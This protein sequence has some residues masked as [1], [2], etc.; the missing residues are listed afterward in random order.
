MSDDV[1][2]YTSS[3]SE[4][5]NTH[6]NG[7]PSAFGKRVDQQNKMQPD[8]CDPGEAGDDMK[9]EKKNEQAGP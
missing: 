7:V 3:D 8:Y 2:D 4:S 6:Y 5:G 1:K 9:A